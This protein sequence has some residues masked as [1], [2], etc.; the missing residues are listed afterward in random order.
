LVGILQSALAIDETL[1][2][3]PSTQKTGEG[4]V[5]RAVP[6]NVAAVTTIRVAVFAARS[7]PAPRPAAPRHVDFVKDVQPIFREHCDECRGA[8][9]TSATNVK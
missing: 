3:E 4:C 5:R 7:S 9:S 1:G 2:A 8:A 6:T